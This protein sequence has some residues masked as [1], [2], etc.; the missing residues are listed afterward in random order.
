MLKNI[1]LFSGVLLMTGCFEKTP[2]C[3]DVEVVELLTKV[4]SNDSRTA[5]VNSDF[6]VELSQNKENGIRTCSAKNVEFIYKIDKNNEFI[7]SLK[8]A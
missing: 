1:I 5:K 7:S 6:I 4:L 3:S 8:K 2:K